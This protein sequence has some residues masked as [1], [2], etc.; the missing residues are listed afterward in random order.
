MKRAMKRLIKASG[1]LVVACLVYVLL[2]AHPEP[3]FSCSVTYSEITFY[4]HSP[5][6]PQVADIASAVEER[7]S[8]SE[9]N[10]PALGQKVFVVGRPWL[11]DVLNGPY[12]R[13]I[14]RNVE[15]S[16]SILIPQLDVGRSQIVHFD[17]RRAGAVNVLT[18]EAVHTLVRRRIGLVRL[19]RLQWWQKEGYAEYVASEAA[20][21]S[22][23]PLQY[24]RAAIAWKYLLEKRRLS[25]DQ[26]IELDDSL[27]QILRQLETMPGGG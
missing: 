21:R 23:A 6:P 24:Q 5:L 9:L 2:L 4:S 25:F 27:P 15:L 14:A 10:A 18:H 12:R 20:T 17:G 26:V 22:E 3:L 7:L 11:W 16:D 19:W 8:T 13:A 1:A